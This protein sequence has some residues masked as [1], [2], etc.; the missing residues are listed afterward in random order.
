[1]W[2][3]IRRYLHF[4]ILAAAF[5]VGEV[6][7]DLLQPS[8]MRRIVDDG[9]L[10]VS[11]GG[12]GSLPLIWSLGLRMILLVLFG[13]L[14][15]SL[16]NA[17]VHM[18]GQNI[19][20]EMR[21]DCF[22]NIMTF[23]FP[24]M[25]RFGT[26]SLVTRVTNDITQVQTYIST[27]VRGMIRTS[28]LMFGSIFFMFRL[29]PRF[30]LVVLCAFP[31]IVGCMALCLLKANPLFARL[32]AQLDQI[33]AILQ[34]DISGIRIIKACVREAYEKLRFGKANGEL[35]KTQLKVLTIFAFMNP[36][37][38]ALM[39]VVVALILLLGHAEVGAGLSSPGSI[40]AAITYTTQLLNGILQLSMLFQNISRGAASW[41]RV[42]EILHSAPELKDGS[43]DGSTDV[44]GRI[45]FRNVSF[46]YPGSA[47]TVLHDV[48][49]TIEP[50][51]TL[52]ILG[53]TGCGKSTLVHLIPRFYDVTEGAVLVDG[54]DVRDYRQRDLRRKVAIALQRSELFSQTISENIAWGNADADTAAIQAAARVAQADDFIQSTPDGYDTMVAE[55]GMSLSGGQKQRISI[56]RAILKGAEILIF[57]DSTSALDLK[58]EADLYAA[59]KQSHPD[60]TKILIAQRIASVRRADRIAV[61]EGGTIAACGTHE[62]LMAS[63]KTYR[64]IYD[65]QLGEE[66]GHD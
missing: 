60:S 15:G 56:A 35:I 47:Q 13:G 28:M 58:T 49:L 36:A 53:A 40:M 10:G 17:F 22:R 26:G 42:K 45:E 33:N 6:L 63:C 64:D 12:V 52:A 19:G 57:D 62:A 38:N 30:G 24:Q 59:L 16:N 54:V 44:R 18:T 11:T 31:V 66:D 65:S 23:S 55:R 61:L 5:M 32:Q 8:I 14:C 48:N 3:Y 9:V 27:F 41:K 21:K 2:K 43:F 20:N 39:Y 25:D 37:V 1:M 29:N 51:E 34:E 4:S 7:M 50:G 46:A